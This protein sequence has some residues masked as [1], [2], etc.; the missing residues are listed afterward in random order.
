MDRPKV[1]D[2]QLLIT[3]GTTSFHP[4]YRLWDGCASERNTYSS[5]R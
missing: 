5:F 2:L 4:K 1:R 3:N